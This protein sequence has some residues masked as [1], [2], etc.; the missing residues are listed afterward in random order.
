MAT[1]PMVSEERRDNQPSLPNTKILV[2]LTIYIDLY[3][4]LRPVSVYG[5]MG[6]RQL[7][8]STETWE[9]YPQG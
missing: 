2:L 9:K 3:I 7:N 6:K 5:K 1:C 4:I 8:V